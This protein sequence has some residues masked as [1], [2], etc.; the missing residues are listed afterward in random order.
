LAVLFECELGDIDRGCPL[1]FISQFP[2]EDEI[3]IPAMSYL[4]ITGDPYVM[5]TSK[6]SGVFVTVYP[7][8]INCNQKSQTIEEIE[9]RRKNDILSMTFYIQQELLRDWTPVLEVLRKLSEKQTEALD[10][11]LTKA[12]AEFAS[13]RHAFHT[14]DAKDFNKDTTYKDDVVAAIGFKVQKMTEFGWIAFEVKESEFNADNFVAWAAKKGYPE[15]VKCL[16]SCPGFS[17][18]STMVCKAQPLQEKLKQNTHQTH[19]HTHFKYS[20]M[21]TRNFVS[22]YF[23]T[24]VLI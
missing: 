15:L 11:A 18:D 14:R 24:C 8:R 20:D 7:A 21:R 12:L 16:L 23:F 22:S 5:E 9:A 10:E 17:V 13:L 1:S 4:E 2:G 19:T 3:L 6:G